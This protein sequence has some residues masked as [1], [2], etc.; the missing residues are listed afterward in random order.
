MTHNDEFKGF[1][2]K[3]SWLDRDIIPELLWRE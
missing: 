3:R 2:R 1:G